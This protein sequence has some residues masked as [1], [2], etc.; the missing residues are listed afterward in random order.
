MAVQYTIPFTFNPDYSH[1]SLISHAGISEAQVILSDP[2]NWPVPV[3][4]LSGDA[5]VG[6]SHLAAQVCQT[7]L[8]R[9][10]CADPLKSRNQANALFHLINEVHA[11]DGRL[12]IMSRQHPNQI[13]P[14]LPDLDSRLRAALHFP[15]KEPVD[16]KIRHAIFFKICADHHFSL[17]LATATYALNRLP[18]S[19]VALR[20]FCEQAART[21]TKAKLSKVAAKSLIETVQ[22]TLGETVSNPSAVAGNYLN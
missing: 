9:D 19:L 11:H 8:Q 22:S 7:V 21:H 14:G 18:Q 20:L 16:G 17:D 13:Y 10:L 5:A 2:L 6:K 1:A 12:L 3:L 15:L 4:I